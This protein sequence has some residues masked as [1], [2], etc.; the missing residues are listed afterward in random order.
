[1]S[2][3]C[4]FTTQ[5]KREARCCCGRKKRVLEGLASANRFSSPKR[6][7][8]NVCSNALVKESH[9]VA[10]NYKWNKRERKPQYVGISLKTITAIF[11][12]NY[13][14]KKVDSLKKEEEM[15]EKEGYEG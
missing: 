3:L 11:K 15:D 13:L 8:H 10:S 12:L 5:A 14:S 4:L 2:S 6:Y 9:R 1:M 7:T